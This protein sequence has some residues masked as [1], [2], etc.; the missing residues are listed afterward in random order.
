MANRLNARHKH[1][2][3]VCDDKFTWEEWQVHREVI[4]R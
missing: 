4:C 3:W 2:C 1:T